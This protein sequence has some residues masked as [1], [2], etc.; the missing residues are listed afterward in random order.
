MFRNADT[1]KGTIHCTLPAAPFGDVF[2]SINLTVS[3]SGPSPGGAS[4][5]PENCASWNSFSLPL[6]RLQISSS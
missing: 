6:S 3:S 4:G 1:R 5:Q 2:G